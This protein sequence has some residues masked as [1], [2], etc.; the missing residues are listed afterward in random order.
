M[1]HLRTLAGGRTV[2]MYRSF[3]VWV[4]SD[5]TSVDRVVDMDAL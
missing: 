3:I 2:E 5:N 1:K 4:I